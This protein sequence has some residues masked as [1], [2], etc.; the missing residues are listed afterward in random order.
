[1]V[2]GMGQ[3][4]I[5][6]QLAEQGLDGGPH[7]LGKYVLQTDRQHL[8][9]LGAAGPLQVVGGPEGQLGHAWLQGADHLVVAV[10]GPLRRHRKWVGTIQQQ[11][12]GGAQGGQVELAA[13]DR[14]AT[15][16]G[17]Q[18]ADPGAGPEGNAAIE[19]ELGVGAGV[20]AAGQFAPEQLGHHRRIG[21][22]G[23][24]EGQQQPAMTGLKPLHGQLQPLDSIHL[25]PLEA[26]AAQPQGQQQPG[27]E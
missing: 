3:A 7:R 17:Q 9:C 19:Q 4:P 26:T 24:A 23:V 6:L 21:Q 11:G 1:M 5:R 12:P 22:A 8:G 16:P 14:A 25:D 27:A 2:G 13:L 18:P 15:E 20:E 10:G